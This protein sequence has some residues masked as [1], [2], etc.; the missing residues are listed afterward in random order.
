MLLTANSL[1]M[2]SPSAAGPRPMPYAARKHVPLRMTK[3]CCRSVT[4]E[5]KE[6]M[7]K[8]NWWN[9]NSAPNMIAV[10]DTQELVDAL[11][12]AGEKL[13]IVEFYAPWCGAC[14]ALYPKICKIMN[15]R[16]EDVLFI[17]VSFEDNKEIC[18]TMGVKVLPFFH[19]YRGAEGKVDQFS[20]TVSKIQKLK[21]LG[22]SQSSLMVL[23]APGRSGHAKD[24]CSRDCR[25][26][27]ESF[28]ELAAS[29]LRGHVGGLKKVQN[30]REP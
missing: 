28:R 19:F 20:C 21:I 2:A 24:D 9:K 5:T 17:K 23:F 11:A 16:T 25:E 10:R 7:K 8:E 4:Q 14:K 1:C 6:V 18:R 22:V 30:A 15:E 13:V 3:V 26:F 27:A 29:L 12:S